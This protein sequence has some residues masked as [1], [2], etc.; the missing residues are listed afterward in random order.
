MITANFRTKA[1]TAFLWLV[2]FMA[3]ARILPGRASRRRRYKVSCATS[4]PS[5]L[6]PIFASL[7]R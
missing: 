7:S 3:L 6:A 1:T 2:R 5:F 4:D